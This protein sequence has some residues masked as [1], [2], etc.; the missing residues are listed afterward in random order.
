MPNLFCWSDRPE[1]EQDKDFHNWNWCYLH[2]AAEDVMNGR[3]DELEKAGKE[4]S[5]A[6]DIFYADQPMPL[7][8][9]SYP[10]L[11]YGQPATAVISTHEGRHG[12]KDEY[13]GHLS[14]RVYLNSDPIQAR[15][16]HC[17]KPTEWR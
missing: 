13:G 15:I 2:G 3:L 11:L 1:G 10:V 4:A 12:R 16:D 7:Q 17:N 8:S 14:G 9:G 6:P 5:H